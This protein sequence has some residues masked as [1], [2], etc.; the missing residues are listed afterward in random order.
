VEAERNQKVYRALPEIF[1]RKEAIEI[2]KKNG[3]SQSII[4]RWKKSP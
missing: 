4:K 1:Q 3:V 2:G